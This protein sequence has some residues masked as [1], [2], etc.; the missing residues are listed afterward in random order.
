M[1]RRLQ[2][3]EATEPTKVVNL[4]ITSIEAFTLAERIRKTPRGQLDADGADELRT[5]DRRYAEV[6]LCTPE[7]IRAGQW[8]AE[9]EFA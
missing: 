6:I 8:G 9:A 5:N 3:G 1:G 4:W 7:R 2:Q